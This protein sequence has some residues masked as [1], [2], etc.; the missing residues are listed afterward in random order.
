MVLSDII[1]SGPVA[2]G[3]LGG[4]WQA[5]MLSEVI[6]R[7]FNI[8]YTEQHVRRLT[9]DLGFS[10]QSPT[11][12]LALGDPLAKEKWRKY[13]Y[14]LVKKQAQNDGGQV[15]FED[16]VTFRQDSTLHRTWS[17]I[18]DQPLVKVTGGRKS[19]K[20]FGAVNLHSGRL[21]CQESSSGELNADTYLRFLHHLAS[22]S[23][24][25]K[26]YL[27]HD[28]ASYHHDEAVLGFFQRYSKWIAAHPLPPYSPELN[29]IECVWKYF[30]K[31]GTHNQFFRDI[32][33]VRTCVNRVKRKIQNNPSL[34]SGYLRPFL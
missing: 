6:L 13:T 19:M 8:R 15:I 26:I 28:N 4:V 16:E 29:P 27:I 12:F 9:R 7:Q 34:I 20:M 24:G 2:Y 33:E 17:R 11:R 31:T 18:G 32:D 14:P 1:D 21:L 25:R 23:N 10:I 22:H 3:Y 30:R 5:K